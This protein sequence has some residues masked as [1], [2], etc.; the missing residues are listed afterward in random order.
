MFQHRLK[1]AVAHRLAPTLAQKVLN[2]SPPETVQVIMEFP[3][4]HSCRSQRLRELIQKEGGRI[5]YELPLINSLAVELPSEALLR[6]IPEARVKMVWPDAKA[7]P[8]LDVAVPAIGADQVYRTGL[9]GKGVVVAVIDTGIAPHVDLM[10]PEPR[11][12]GWYDLVNGKSEPYDDEGHGTHVAGIIAGNGYESE[13]KYT[14]VAPGALLVGV[15]ALD[16]RGSGPISRVIAGI[17]WVV[18]HKEEYRIKILNLSLGAPPEEGY[19]TDP[20]SKAVE[21]A[22]RAGLLVCAAAGNMG[23][24][25]RTITTPG[26][27]PRALTVGSINDQGTIPRED[28]VINDFSSR[29]PT[30]DRLAKPDLVAPG[31]N[32]TSLR[33]DGG[34]VSLSGTS[35]ATPMVAGAAA[36]LWEKDPALTPNQVRELL[37]ATAEDRGYN[38]LI[39][40]AGY[41]NVGAALEKL[42]GNQAA[43]PS[44]SDD[45]LFT[46]FLTLG[47]QFAPGERRQELLTVLTNHL[48]AALQKA[49]WFQT[50]DTSFYQEHLPQVLYTLGECLFRQ[51]AAEK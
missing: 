26:I 46:F 35:M 16:H 44:P 31:A 29:G 11:I 20:A 43:P 27:S 24:R 12:V 37:V 5:V 18:E 45:L 4:L 38:R 22:W 25:Q 19:R 40:G 1:R 9:T 48:S 13:G 10:K 3:T 34:Y 30:I 23:P 42:A 50:G 2:G 49:G 7:A 36:L 15:K 6:V 8:C 47:L 32:I 51:P 21:A 14:G 17:Q 41:L 33:V 28:D 39:Q